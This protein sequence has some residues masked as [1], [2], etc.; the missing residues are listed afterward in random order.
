V[1][2]G[3]VQVRGLVTAPVRVLAAAPAASA[4]SPRRRALP[5][6]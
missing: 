2:Q 6:Q 1:V 3:V 4:P 5:R